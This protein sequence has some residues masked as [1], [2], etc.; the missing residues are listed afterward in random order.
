MAALARALTPTVEAD[1]QL[2]ELAAELALRGAREAEPD[3]DDDELDRR[4]DH[5]GSVVTEMLGLRAT[6]LTGLR[7]KAQ[8]AIW[9]SGGEQAWRDFHAAEAGSTYDQVVHSIVADLVSL[10]TAEIH[11][12]PRPP[13]AEAAAGEP[14]DSELRRAAAEFVACR[15]QAAEILKRLETASAAADAM[16]PDVPELIRDPRRPGQWLDRI[17]L[18]RMD[19]S[20]RQLTWPK[21]EGSPRV[22]AFDKWV[23]LRDLIDASFGVPGLDEAWGKARD[24]EDAAADRVVAAKPKT[25]EEAVVKYAVLLASFA[26]ADREDISAPIVF[27]NFLKDLEQLAEIA[28]S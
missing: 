7:S 22:E 16:Y 2:E 11:A 12:F 9:A 28:K 13:I 20:S 25:I 14:Q 15:A 5:A 1:V 26:S 27:F 18:Q 6:G 23:E 10:P 24:A 4:A 21:P 3:L 19:D 8:A 17:T